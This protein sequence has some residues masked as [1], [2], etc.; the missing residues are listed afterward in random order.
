MKAVIRRYLNEIV[1]I[2]TLAL[3]SVALV[4]GQT[5]T[6]ARASVLALDV[7][8]T[9]LTRLNLE[10]DTLEAIREILDGQLGRGE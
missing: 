5:D 6:A 3:M 10:Q 7:N 2:A 8:I 9:E 1:S 4:A